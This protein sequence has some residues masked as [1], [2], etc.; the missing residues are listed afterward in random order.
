MKKGEE[1]G[2]GSSGEM[3]N[4]ETSQLKP[5]LDRIFADVEKNLPSV[6][7]DMSDVSLYVMWISVAFYI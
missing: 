5:K 3:N 4:S 1:G 2:K 6:D 7:F